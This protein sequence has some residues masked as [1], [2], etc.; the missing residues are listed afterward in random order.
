MSQIQ[1]ESETQ[2]RLNE[3][4]FTNFCMKQCTFSKECFGDIRKSNIFKNSF[5]YFH[6]DYPFRLEIQELV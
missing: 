6:V 2:S 3:R 5:V 1:P 4:M